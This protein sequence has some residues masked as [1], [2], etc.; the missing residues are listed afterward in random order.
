M[1]PIDYLGNGTGPASLGSPGAGTAVAFPHETY[2]TPLLDLTKAQ[3]GI[4]LL[5]AKPGYFPILLQ[6]T[7]SIEQV[8]GTQ[9]VPAS[10]QAGS[11]A[12]HSNFLFASS[13]TPSNANVNAANPPS[14]AAGPSNAT[15]Q[16]G[17]QTNAPIFLDI[18]S[19]CQGTGGFQLKAKLFM[20]VGWLATG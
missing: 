6:T 12:A 9:T 15:F 18:T 17:L 20:L 8:S 5:P 14:I 7:W 13:T 3:L 1:P 19:P 4:E 2:V 16:N 11:D 10:V